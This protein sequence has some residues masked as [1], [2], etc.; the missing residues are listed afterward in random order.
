MSG[1]L[2]HDTFGAN[3]GFNF[4]CQSGFQTQ[5]LSYGF[6]SELWL[7]FVRAGGAEPEGA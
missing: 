4:F 6:R 2:F 7:W 1:L 5:R 3:A